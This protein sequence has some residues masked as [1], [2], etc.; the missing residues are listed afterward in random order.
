MAFLPQASCR[1]AYTRTICTG[2]CCTVHSGAPAVA[3][4]RSVSSRT[5][6]GSL[7]HPKQNLVETMGLCL[8]AST[9]RWC[10]PAPIF[11]DR[12]LRPLLATTYILYTFISALLKKGRK[13]TQ[14]KISS[15]PKLAHPGL[16]IQVLAW[17]LGP[18]FLH[19]RSPTGSIFVF[20][21]SFVLQ[22]SRLIRNSGSC[23][24]FVNAS[25]LIFWSFPWTFRPSTTQHLHTKDAGVVV[26]PR[27]P[28]H[29]K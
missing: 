15:S 21:W 27:F 7:H 28:S 20:L 9:R 8:R 26:F 19:T 4:S 2:D 11:W 3:P 13:N 17:H 14:T 29:A 16:K 25:L 12:A 10:W 24:I 22:N 6:M 5:S 18:L 1:P 23:W